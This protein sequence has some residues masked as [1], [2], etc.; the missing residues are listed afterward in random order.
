MRLYSV[1]AEVSVR[2]KGRKRRVYAT[3]VLRAV[4]INPSIA[5]RLIARSVAFGTWRKNH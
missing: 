3:E 1:P 4:E 2:A 5:A